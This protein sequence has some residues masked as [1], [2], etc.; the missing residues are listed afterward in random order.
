MVEVSR[1]RRR[2]SCGIAVSAGTLWEVFEFTL[3]RT[4]LFQTQKG[5]TDTMLDLVADTVGALAT[6]G[7]FA[8]LVRINGVRLD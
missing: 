4:G 1:R 3:D 5:L 8:G 6:M 2:R 7:L